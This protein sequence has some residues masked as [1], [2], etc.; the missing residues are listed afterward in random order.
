MGSKGAVVG[1]NEDWSEE[2]VDDLYIIKCQLPNVKFMALNYV[3]TVA[4]LGVGMND[5][6]LVSCV[7]ELH[8]K[9][10]IGVPKIIIARALLEQDTVANAINFIVNTPKASGF[11]HLIACR[12]EMAD[13]E[14]QGNNVAVLGVG[15]RAFVHTNH[16]LNPEFKTTEVNHTIS[17]ERRYEKAN[18]LIRENM[19]VED[20]KQ[21][22]RDTSDE[23]YPIC[24]LKETIGSVVAQ[25][26][27][28]KLHVCYGPP[29]I[30]DYVEYDLL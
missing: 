22:L 7:N 28:M 27:T 4:G 30:G 12:K 19:S 14:V 10:T 2:A 25:P 5:F 13:V 23:E 6:G 20:M 29:C 18:E 16:Y 3:G 1:H 24:R 9:I 11:N 17:S 8:Q 21:L 15:S 26:D